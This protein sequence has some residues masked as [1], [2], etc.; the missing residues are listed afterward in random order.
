MNINEKIYKNAGKIKAAITIGLI[1]LFIYRVYLLT[2]GESWL[3]MILKSDLAI[4]SL[5][6]CGVIISEIISLFLKRNAA[7]FLSVINIIAG[8]GVILINLFIRKFMSYFLITAM[9][10]V[11]NYGIL[12]EIAFSI[13]L[14]V[15]AAA[16]MFFKEQSVRL[17]A[18]GVTKNENGNG[19]EEKNP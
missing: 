17:A 7:T 14:T 5:V 9:F 8:I 4:L 12:S 19:N 3:G 15:I 13:L 1:A 10:P 6:P 16:I 2:D 11:T 18:T